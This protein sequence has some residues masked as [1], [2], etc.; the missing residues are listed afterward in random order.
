MGDFSH[1]DERILAWDEKSHTGMKSGGSSHADLHHNEKLYCSDLRSGDEENWA[2]ACPIPECGFPEAEW[3]LPT[4]V[5]IILGVVVLVWLCFR[6]RRQ[7]NKC[8]RE[9]GSYQHNVSEAVHEKEVVSDS[10]SE[11]GV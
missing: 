8:K 4:R 2:K 10:A 6:S 11:K 7:K 5:I 9:K 1:H 3:I